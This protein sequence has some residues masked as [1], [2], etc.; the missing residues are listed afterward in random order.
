MNTIIF[1]KFKNVCYVFSVIFYNIIIF[2]KNYL[3]IY[4]NLLLLS[5]LW[6]Y[7]WINE[8]VTFFRWK[9][10]WTNESV[11]F[12]RWTNYAKYYYLYKTL[13]Y[14][15]Y[16]KEYNELILIIKYKHKN[17]Q[18]FNQLFL[19][20]YFRKNYNYLYNYYYNIL[21][22][23]KRWIKTYY[24]QTVYKNKKKEYAEY[25]ISY[26]KS[27][28][29]LINYIKEKLNI[30][31]WKWKKLYRIWYYRIN[32]VKY[33]RIY[34]MYKKRF[35]SKIKNIN[36]HIKYYTIIDKANL[37]CNIIF[38]TYLKSKSNMII[39]Y[40]FKLLKSFKSY[41]KYIWKSDIIYKFLKSIE[42]KKWYLE[43]SA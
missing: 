25:I 22:N 5:Y 19:D 17:K 42:K 11:T 37:I 31:K 6:K 35:I 13:S 1:F 18:I 36:I 33:K 16:F 20:L 23:Y 12:L 34:L 3:K 9:Y 39:Y 4:Y 32:I 40:Y 29:A 43:G 28:R 15:Y 30:K 38:L 10:T 14:L 24:V 27:K 21:I 41:L 7:T 2:F 26:I 8:S